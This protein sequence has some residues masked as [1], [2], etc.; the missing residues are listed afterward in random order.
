MY[1]DIEGNGLAF[2][3][4]LCSVPLKLSIDFSRLIC[5]C[6]DLKILSGEGPFHL[7]QFICIGNDA[8][9]SKTVVEYL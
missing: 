3:G 5:V 2:P 6:I 9:D 1:L 4:V 7:Q 8:C